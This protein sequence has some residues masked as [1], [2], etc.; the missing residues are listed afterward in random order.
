MLH[1]LYLHT[2]S[3]ECFAN[4]MPKPNLVP[5]VN[6]IYKAAEQRQAAELYLFSIEGKHN[7]PEII[8]FKPIL[9]DS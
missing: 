8:N 4:F 6:I 5:F 1:K 9:V 3:V 7:N 2:Y